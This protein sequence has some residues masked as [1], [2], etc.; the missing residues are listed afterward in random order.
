MENA[1][2]S[3]RCFFFLIRDNFN[4]GQLS[5]TIQI[6]IYY[7]HKIRTIIPFLHQVFNVL[8]LCLYKI[9][10]THLIIDSQ[11]LIIFNNTNKTASID[12]A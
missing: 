6:G 3:E 7:V 1:I 9:L 5:E 10:N 4:E 2:T 8:L 11:I 12:K